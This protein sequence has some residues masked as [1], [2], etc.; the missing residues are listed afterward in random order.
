MTAF[1]RQV[2]MPERVRVAVLETRK[3]G[4][5]VMRLLLYY[6]GLE[7]ADV[8]VNRMAVHGLTRDMT[9][10]VYRSY[11]LIGPES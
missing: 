2:V 3:I 5:G 9:F 4:S 10:G 7:L 8:N 11:Q 6:I 1:P